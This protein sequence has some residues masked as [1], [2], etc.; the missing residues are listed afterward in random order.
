MDKLDYISVDKYFWLR[1]NENYISIGFYGLPSDIHLTVS[2]H[3]N[4][5][6]INLH[7]TKNVETND[8]KPKIEI[9]RIEKN[10]LQETLQVGLNTLLSNIV[11]PIDTNTLEKNDM[12]PEYI[13]M[14]QIDEKTENA[15]LNLFK[16]DE[17]YEIKKKRR[18]KIITDM[19]TKFK[20]ISETPE[21]V[22]L[23]R[24]RTQ[25]LDRSTKQLESGVIVTSG[26]SFVAMKIGDNWYKFRDKID[27]CI[28]LKGIVQRQTVTAIKWRFKKSLEIIRQAKTYADTAEYDMK[29]IVLEKPSI[30]T[31]DK[32]VINQKF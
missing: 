21:F 4:D 13:A 9:C 7:L 6:N 20:Q 19:E 26:E 24:T 27:I 18:L 29:R 22:E 11:E 5:T 32:E 25:L 17:D 30:N 8:R 2:Y 14:D 1:F 15:I 16:K 3:R 31:P 10:L 23:Y 28:L 12:S